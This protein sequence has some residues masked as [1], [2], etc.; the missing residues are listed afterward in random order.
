MSEPAVHLLE[1]RLAELE[2]ILRSVYLHRPPIERYVR[3]SVTRGAWTVEPGLEWR[4]GDDFEALSGDLEVLACGLASIVDT[5]RD[6]AAAAR[7]GEVA[8]AARW[9]GRAFFIEVHAVDGRWIQ[10][11]QPYGV[12]RWR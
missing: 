9:P 4:E 5:H 2:Q 7:R 11:Y 10:I 3:C 1:R 6:P 8:F 12:P